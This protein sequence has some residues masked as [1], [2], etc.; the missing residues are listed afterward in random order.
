LETGNFNEN[1]GHSRNHPIH[2]RVFHGGAEHRGG[3]VHLTEALGFGL[4]VDWK[5]V[6]AL[7]S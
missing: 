4:E 7:R 3:R 5:A 1:Y 2:H 6:K